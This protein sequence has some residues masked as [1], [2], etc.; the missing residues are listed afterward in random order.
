MILGL[1]ASVALALCVF[2]LVLFGAQ[3]NGDWAYALARSNT[4]EASTRIGLLNQTLGLA[5]VVGLVGLG[6]VR[7]MGSRAATLLDRMSRI[8]CPLLLVGVVPPLMSMDAQQEPVQTVLTIAAFTVLFERLLR[9][10]LEALSELNDA[11]VN[12]AIN[13]GVTSRWMYAGIVFLAAAFYAAYMS[14]YTVYAHRRFQTYNFDLGQYDNVFWNALHG[15]PLHCTPIGAFTDW[16]SMSSHA[17]LGVYFLL[18]LY[19]LRPRAETLLVMQACI[20]GLGAVPLYFFAVRR[21]EPLYACVLAICYL[22]FPPLHG[23]NFYD[24]HFQPIAATLVFFVIWFVDTRRWVLLTIVFVMALSC[25]EDISIGLTMLGVYLVLSG[26][27]PKPGMIMA[28]AGAFYF[29]MMRFVIMQH[30]GPGWFSDMYKDLYPKPS[31]PNSYGG[32]MQ[33]LATN[34]LY[35]FRTL[36]TQD[37]LRYLLQIVTPV[38]F[39]PFRRKYLLPALAPGA[40]F[41]LL[42][43]GYEPTTDIAFQYSGHFSPYLFSAS[44]LALSA[45]RLE[46]ANRVKLRAA[47][48]ALVTGTVLCTSYWGAFPPRSLKGGFSTISFNPPTPEQDQ[49]ARDLVELAAMIPEGDSFA[50][51]EEELPHVSGR[52][53]VLTLKYSNNSADYLLYGTSS[54]GSTVGNQARTDGSYIELA[55]RPGLVLLKRK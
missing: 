42:T 27:R 26:H 38:A 9:I 43:T 21:L 47:L 52:L 10:S 20:L 37:K 14:K 17:D 34:P 35:V 8:A 22:L 40:L 7:L 45:Y 11:P 46:D 15:R 44:A 49:K 16:S 30:F 51:S 23:A 39:L 18:P 12:L 19:A 2:S 1:R 54:M 55:T 28:A 48:A 13:A 4:L 33:T 25:R 24:F 29:V 3:V 41:T 31:G 6:W 50:V 5:A 32:V 36:L 53:N